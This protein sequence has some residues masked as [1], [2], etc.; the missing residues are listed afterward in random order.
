MNATKVNGSMN[1]SQIKFIQKHLI[2]VS[3]AGIQFN[4]EWKPKFL[5]ANVVADVGLRQ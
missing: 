5:P 1:D 4:I 2:C 3:P